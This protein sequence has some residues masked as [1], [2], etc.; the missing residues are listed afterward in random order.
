MFKKK[1]LKNTIS[2]YIDPYLSHNRYDQMSISP[3]SCGIQLQFDVL[4]A[5]MS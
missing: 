4:H 2:N 1:K 3:D 5:F